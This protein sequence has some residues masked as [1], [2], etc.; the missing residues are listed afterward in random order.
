MIKEFTGDLIQAFEDDTKGDIRV[1]AHGVNCRG[2]MGAGFALQV[3][4]RWP[5]VQ[6]YN[7]LCT[8]RGEVIPGGTKTV[9]V[10]TSKKQTKP[11]MNLYTQFDVGKPVDVN[12]HN[13][14]AFDTFQARYL[15]IEMTIGHLL[16]KFPKGAAIPR[17]GAGFAGLDWSI[18]RMIIE[19]VSK[20]REISIYTL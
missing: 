10:N 17:I 12:L 8:I 13:V 18:V 4:T 16:D 9:Y 2:V 14:S 7:K 6:E 5:S 15:W 1:M 11:I 19:R 20:G 3:A